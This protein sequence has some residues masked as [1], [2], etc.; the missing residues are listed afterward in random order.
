MG[1]GN[2]ECQIGRQREYEEKLHNDAV[3][4]TPRDISHKSTILGARLNI[5]R[6]STGKFIPV[7][8]AD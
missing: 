8:Y 6:E 2:V 5:L 3:F 4:L 1:R 7:V